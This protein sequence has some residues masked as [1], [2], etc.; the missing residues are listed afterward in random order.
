MDFA[1]LQAPFSPKQVSWRVGS[2][3]GDKSKG[4]AL[5]YIDARDVMQRLDEVVSPNGWQARYSHADKKTICELSIK[6][7]DEWITKANGAGDSDIEAEK[8][9][10][11]DAFKRAAV[12][13]GIGRYLYDL[14]SP[15]VKLELSTTGKVKGIDKSEYPRL[16]ALLTKAH[17]AP[18][19]QET[20]VPYKPAE[21]PEL[22]EKQKQF[23][24]WAKAEI[25]KLSTYSITDIGDW[26]VSEDNY[27]RL[28]W[29]K[30]NWPSLYAEFVALGVE[31]SNGRAQ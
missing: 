6:C 27:K 4:Q 16:E 25:A 9:A 14:D 20:P 1:A 2:T 13:W 30:D 12:M 24:A 10:I 21:L 17:V 19:G 31:V 18:T 15:W 22:S 23:K 7:G 8:G 28:S 11:S 26:F 3:T 5:A 29:A